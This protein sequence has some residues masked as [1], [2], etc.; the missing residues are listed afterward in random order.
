MSGTITHDISKYLNEIIRPY[1][2]T[3]FIIKSST[4]AL[5]KIADIKINNEIVTS[6]DVESLFTNVPV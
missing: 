3:N 1:L 2:N 6:L 5:L 4:E